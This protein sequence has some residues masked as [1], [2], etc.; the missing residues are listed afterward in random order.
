MDAYRQRRTYGTTGARI[1]LE[2]EAHGAG[3]GETL[4]TDSPCDLHVTVAGTAPIARIEVFQGLTSM[5][6]RSLEGDR[7]G[8]VAFPGLEPDEVEKGYAVVVEQE[9]GHR[10]WSSPIWV[11]KE[12]VP[13]LAWSVEKGGAPALT[14]QGPGR[15]DNVVVVHS[16]TEH[17]FANEGIAGYEPPVEETA[18][19]LWTVPKDD[20]TVAV[21]YR[22]RGSP[23]S[24]RARIRGAED[25]SVDFCREWFLTDAEFE[26][27]GQ[28]DCAFYTGTPFTRINAL[29]M[30]FLVTVDPGEATTFTLE[31]GEPRTTYVGTAKKIE[32]STAISLDGREST[33]PL[34]V[35]AVVSLGPGESW[36]GPAE[37]GYWAADPANALVETD[38]SNN[39]LRLDARAAK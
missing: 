17:P 5:G 7:E 29:G 4:R 10:A 38:E 28:G 14:N 11:R 12:S 13:D 16:D 24:G 32:A 9:D 26:D 25:Y 34:P 19:Y 23:I 33:G 15:A 8:A 30:D 18:G 27:D 6:K 20:H 36:A 37:Q 2:V 1:F 39:L 35:R 22:W 31:F 21:Y 3:M